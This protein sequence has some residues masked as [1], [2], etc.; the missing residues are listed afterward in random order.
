VISLL[1]EEQFVCHII[2]ETNLQNMTD[3]G[4]DLGDLIG[5][6]GPNSVP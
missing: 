5:V 6:T 1:F 4:V 2:F 3:L